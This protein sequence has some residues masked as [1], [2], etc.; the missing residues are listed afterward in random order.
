MLAL[1]LDITKDDDGKWYVF[2]RCPVIMGRYRLS[3]VGSDTPED[4]LDLLAT[5]LVNLTQHNKPEKL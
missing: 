3:N 2:L 5:S 1:N 4:A